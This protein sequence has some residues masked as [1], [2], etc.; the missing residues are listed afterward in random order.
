MA[1]RIGRHEAPSDNQQG[2]NG[3]QD[4]YA[5]PREQ[6][7]IVGFRRWYP[8]RSRVDPFPVFGIHSRHH[9]ATATTVDALCDLSHVL[10]MFYDLRRP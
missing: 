1:W 7:R 8:L 2:Y 5:R 10:Y 4:D 3:D 6:F 9:V